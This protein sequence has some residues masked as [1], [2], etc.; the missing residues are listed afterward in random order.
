MPFMGAIRSLLQDRRIRDVDIDSP[1]ALELHRQITMEK[2]LMRGVFHDF[3]D[4]CVGLGREHLKGPGKQV[5][6]GAGGSFFKDY[7]PEVITTDV[8]PSGHL[9]MILDAQDM[10]FEKES[11]AVFYGINCFH[12]LPNPRRFFQELGRVLIPG[13]GC[14]LIEP[15]NSW[16]SRLIHSHIH[17]HEHFDQ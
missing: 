3:Y 2:P 6:I 8:K 13:G 16:P 1:E 17:S 12:H 14:I 10:K 11:V 5:E 4:V 7:Y 15:Y 9:D